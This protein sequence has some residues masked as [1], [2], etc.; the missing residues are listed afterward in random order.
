MQMI[1]LPEAS[2]FIAGSTPEALSLTTS[3]QDSEFVQGVQETARK[4]HMWVSVGVHE[5]V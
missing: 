4:E 1:F 5:K 3:I 2:D